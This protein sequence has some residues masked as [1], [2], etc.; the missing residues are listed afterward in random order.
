MVSHYG[1]WQANHATANAAHVGVAAM[2]VHTTTVLFTVIT[3]PVT[4]I[5]GATLG[6]VV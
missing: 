2:T 6:T 1:S 5:S 3:L 4:A